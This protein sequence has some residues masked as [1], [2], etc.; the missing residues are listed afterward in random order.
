M[1]THWKRLWCWEGLGAGGEGDNRGWDDWMASL[2][3]WMWVWV[4]SGSWWWTGRPGVLRFMGSQRVGHVER[5]NWTELSDLMYVMYV[6]GCRSTWVRKDSFGI[7]K[8]EESRVKT[9][10]WVIITSLMTSFCFMEPLRDTILDWEGSKE[11]SPLG[12]CWL[13]T[14][15]P[16]WTIEPS[17]KEWVRMQWWRKSFYNRNRK[18]L[19]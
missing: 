2:T 4:N 16:L 5:L 8:S 12:P 10:P 11:M 1:A 19:L 6:S 14:V 7:Q 13:Q 17:C 15:L 3:W 9:H 18:V